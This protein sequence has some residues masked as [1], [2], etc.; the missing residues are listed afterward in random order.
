[1][2]SKIM[3]LFLSLFL[4]LTLLVGL[5]SSAKFDE[6]FQPYWASD[7][8]TYEGELLHMKLDNYSGTYIFH[9]KRFNL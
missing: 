9:L 2:A 3:S 1:M 5:V 7:H 4:G 6:L 8:F